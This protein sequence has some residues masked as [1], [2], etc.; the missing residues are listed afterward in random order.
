MELPCEICVAKIP[1]KGELFEIVGIRCFLGSEFILF[2]TAVYGTHWIGYGIWL[3]LFSEYGKDTY[4]GFG[5]G[6]V[7]GIED[8][9]GPDGIHTE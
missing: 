7:P 9:T 4:A 6:S 2:D 8:C 1:P 3:D 5:K